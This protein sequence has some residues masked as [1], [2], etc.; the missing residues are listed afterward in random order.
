MEHEHLYARTTKMSSYNLSQLAN[1]VPHVLSQVQKPRLIPA[2]GFDH[3]PPS[4]PRTEEQ[5]SDVENASEFDHFFDWPL[6]DHE[7]YNEA[8]SSN[9]SDHSSM[10]GLTSASTPTPSDEG[11]ASPSPLRDVEDRFTLRDKLKE[12]KQSDD[13]YTFPQRELKPRGE[14]KYYPNIQIHNHG[15]S[16]PSS[17]TDFSGTVGGGS[18]LTPPPSSRETSARPSPRAN[19]PAPRG[20][21]TGPLKNGDEVAGVRS[22]G[23]CFC[24]KLR[25]VK[26]DDHSCPPRDKCI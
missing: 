24:C 11:G 21:R 18:W 17:A 23:S 4:P 1:S 10:P 13:K 26:V 16:P 5:A 8:E 25:K 7:Q 20:K 14:P 2:L 3:L 22:T 19:N 12:V 9:K 6:Y 15:Q